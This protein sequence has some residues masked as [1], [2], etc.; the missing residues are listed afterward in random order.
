MYKEKSLD[1]V[2]G[3]AIFFDNVRVDKYVT[4]FNVN[5]YSNGSMGNANIGMIYIKDLYKVHTK[6]SQGEVVSTQDGIED[7]TNVKIF[8]RN[9][10][11]G[12][13]VSVFDG[14]IKGRSVQKTP[15]GMTIS[16]S[17]IDYMV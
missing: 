12:K 16:Y 5:L 13:Y 1:A 9:I 7:G 14:I 6:N 8:V 2:P 17:A 15:G 11:N 4:N 3:Y 10:F